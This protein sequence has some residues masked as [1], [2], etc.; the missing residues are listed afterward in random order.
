MSQAP[1]KASARDFIRDVLIGRILEGVLAPG[2]RLVERTLAGEFGTSLSP[3]REALRE[4]ESMGYIESRRYS[5]T[6]VR[7]IS[8]VEMADAYQVRAYLDKL[9]GELFVER[10]E[11]TGLDSLQKQ[12]VAIQE[13]AS[14]G[15]V[16][17]Y[18]RLDFDWHR[19]IVSLSGNPVLLRSWDALSIRPRI[20]PLI[21]ELSL[22]LEVLASQHNAVLE[23]MAA[24][25][26]ASVGEHLFSHAM[27]IANRIH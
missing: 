21:R 15:E 18:A 27:G 12:Q 22:D 4:L 25:D 23:A 9:A 13:A 26:A 1:T 24:E 11:P 7:E 8:A 16:E 10:M 20:G 14:S 5:G 19:E 17:T 6:Y 2:D 3:V